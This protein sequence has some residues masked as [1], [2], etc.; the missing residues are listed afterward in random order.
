MELLVQNLYNRVAI[1]FD[2]LTKTIISGWRENERRG[3]RGIRK[4]QE[5]EEKNNGKRESIE[6]E[7]QMRERKEPPSASFVHGTEY[8]TPNIRL[9][10]VPIVLVEA[11]ARATV[12]VHYL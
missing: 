6:P 4:R 3:K 11:P 5:W 7:T 1:Y 10:V 12:L 8:G 2:P 9:D